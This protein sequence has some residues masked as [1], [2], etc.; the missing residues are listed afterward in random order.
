MRGLIIRYAPFGSKLYCDSNDV[1][2]DLFR[3]DRN[4]KLCDSGLIIS[5]DTRIFLQLNDS[6][7]IKSTLM[8]F[9]SHFQALTQI[10]ACTISCACSPYQTR[11]RT[12]FDA[13]PA[14]GTSP[15]QSWT[16]G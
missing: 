6:N 7:G 15:S 8:P 16:L 10:G 3:E 1:W 5:K 11:M 12:A 9:D 13:C 2:S 14:F 4:Q